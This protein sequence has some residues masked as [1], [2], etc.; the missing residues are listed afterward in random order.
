MNPDSRKESFFEREGVQSVLASLICIVLG[1]AVGYLVLF[2]INPAGAGMDD[3]L[4]WRSGRTRENIAP[5]FSGLIDGIADSI[6]D[7]CDFLPFVNEMGRL[8]DKCL[9]NVHLGK[10]AVREIVRRISQHERTFSMHGASPC[11]AAPFGPLNTNGTKG[12]K[13][14]IH[15]WVYQSLPILGFVH[16]FQLLERIIASLDR[17]RQHD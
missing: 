16:V 4:L 5:R 7:R 11:L 13:I 9:G 14:K 10:F 8:A 1:L 6:P 12:G 17:V 2:L 3:A 15:L